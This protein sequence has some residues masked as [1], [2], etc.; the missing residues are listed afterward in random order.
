MSE[1]EEQ[2]N[3][4]IPQEFLNAWKED[5]NWKTERAV[6]FAR[7]LYGS[8]INPRLRNWEI[9]GALEKCLAEAG[10][11]R[12]SGSLRQVLRNAERSHPVL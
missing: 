8:R 6:E 9:R 7:L 4:P 12:R 5:S 3:D 1:P 11:D 10:K 2:P